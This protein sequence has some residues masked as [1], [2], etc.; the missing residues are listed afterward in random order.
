MKTIAI[1][2]SANNL[3]RKYIDPAKELVKSLIEKDCRIVWGGSGAGLMGEIANTVK[4]YGGI[5]TGVSLAVFEEYIKED[6]DEIIIAN[7]LSERKAIILVRSDVIIGLVGGTGT[8]DEITELIEL[9]KYKFHNKPI[10]ILNTENFYNGLIIQLN[11]M[12]TDGFA[13][14]ID[15]LIYLADS[16]QQ[17]LSYIEKNIS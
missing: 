2:C 8:L 14:N 7:T 16:P 6:A 11:K 15:D 3:N 12:T 5:L 10:A 9:K 1:F 4:T 13:S 17:L